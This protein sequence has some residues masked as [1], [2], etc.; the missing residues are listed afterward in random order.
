MLV[1]VLLDELV[2]D[3]EEEDQ[4]EEEEEEDEEELELDVSKRELAEERLVQSLFE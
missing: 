4:L 2:L 3:E 1:L